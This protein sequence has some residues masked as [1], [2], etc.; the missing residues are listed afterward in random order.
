MGQCLLGTR[1]SEVRGTQ[2]WW[3]LTRGLPGTSDQDLPPFHHH[4]SLLIATLTEATS[5]AS[6][7]QGM[8]AIREHSEG[9]IWWREHDLCVWGPSLDLHFPP[10]WA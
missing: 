1:Y 10:Q 7:A 4:F 9:R 6:L 5:P 3:R 2:L 8:M